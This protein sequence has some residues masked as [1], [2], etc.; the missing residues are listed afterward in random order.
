MSQPKPTNGTT[1]EIPVSLSNLQRVIGTANTPP[2]VT[3]KTKIP[4][5]FGNSSEDLIDLI[6][7]YEKS[8]KALGW[9]DIDKL[10]R[11]PLYLKGS[12]DDWFETYCDEAVPSRPTTWTAFKTKMLKFSLPCDYAKYVKDKL[13]SF[14]QGY[15]QP[16]NTYTYD[17]TL[18]QATSARYE[19]QRNYWVCY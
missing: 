15:D 6:H 18:M 9:S 12:A 17:A 10:N 13:R 4:Y 2:I 19:R 3:Q 11:V 16:V 14:S 8:A 5:Y 1:A 7:Q